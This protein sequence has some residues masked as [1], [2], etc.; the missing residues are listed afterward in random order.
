[1]LVL[2]LENGGSNCRD[3]ASGAKAPEGAPLTGC[4]LACWYCCCSWGGGGGGGACLG[5]AN[6]DVLCL[7][8]ELPV[9]QNRTPDGRRSGAAS[10]DASSCHRFSMTLRKGRDGWGKEKQQHTGEGSSGAEHLEMAALSVEFNIRT[11]RV[12]L[13]ALSRFRAS[14]SRSE[15][16]R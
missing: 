9:R 2:R 15:R 12:F 8:K 1:M 3:D 16:R 6:S 11:C 7:D 5:C 13:G 14:P 4:P 10:L